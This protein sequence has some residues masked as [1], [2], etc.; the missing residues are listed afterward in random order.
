M[1]SSVLAAFTFITGCAFKITDFIKPW[2]LQETMQ[3]NICSDSRKTF[4]KLR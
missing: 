2:I 3:Q 1:V 4:Q